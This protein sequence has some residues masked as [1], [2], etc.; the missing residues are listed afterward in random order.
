MGWIQSLLRCIGQDAVVLYRVESCDGPLKPR[1]RESTLVSAS[2]RLDIVQE[3][4]GW[5]DPNRTVVLYRQAVPVERILM[6]YL[7]TAAMNHPFREGEAV[8][9]ADPDHLAF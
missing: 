6:T 5:A 9:L 3:M 8:L 2:F 1:V 4:S 7:E